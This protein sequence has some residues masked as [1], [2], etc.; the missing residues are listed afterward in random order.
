MSSGSS[1][2]V[3]HVP[4]LSEPLLDAV[5]LGRTGLGD[6]IAA[7]ARQHRVV[8][9][10]AGLD[11]RV[12]G[13]GVAVHQTSGYAN[14]PLVAIGSDGSITATFSVAGD[15][16]FGSMRVVPDRLREG[17]EAAG[18]LARA[19]WDLLDEREAVQQVAVAAAIPD[20][21]HKVFGAP[22][23]GNSIQLGSFSMP[24]IVVVPE[25]AR[26]VRRAEVGGRELVERLVAEVGRVFTDAG[27]A[28]Q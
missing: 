13:A 21:Q 25:P 9:Q 15:D 6:E 26:I 28:Q 8:P 14:T 4:L 22:A 7:L 19:V 5:V 12:S 16:Q 24:G 18:V 23:G 3:A 10:S 1:A 20:A 11:A 2:R 17:L 27:A